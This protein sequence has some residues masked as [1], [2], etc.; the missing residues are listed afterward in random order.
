[1]SHVPAFWIACLLGKL[2]W[3]ENH[4]WVKSGLGN[5]SLRL[6]YFQFYCLSGHMMSCYNPAL[7]LLRSLASKL[8]AFFFLYADLAYLNTSR[9]FVL[10]R[11]SN[12]P[13]VFTVLGLHRTRAPTAEWCKFVC[14]IS[15]FPTFDVLNGLESLPSCW[16]LVQEKSSLMIFASFFSN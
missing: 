8:I 11:K 13:V 12:F 15:N 16:P 2:K 1:V 4:S 10:G 5:F 3:R 7:S 9:S 6:R 14:C